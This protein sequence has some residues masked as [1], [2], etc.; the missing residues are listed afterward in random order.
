MKSNKLW[1]AIGAT[2]SITAALTLGSAS[3]AQDSGYKWPRMLVVATP[4]T[5]S[6]SFASTNGWAPV[7]QKE[8]G[9]TMRVVPEDSELMR[10]KRLNIDKNVQ[11]SSV[12]S[13]EVSYQIEGRDGYAAAEPVAQRI[14]WHHN[15]TPWGMVVAGDSKLKTIDDLKKG[16]VRVAKGMWSP[17]MMTTVTAS[18]PAYLNL[19]KEEAEKVIRY[20]PIS[21]YA[22]NCRSVVEGKT[23]AAWCAT[24]SA[25]SAEMEGA[26]GS[27]RWLPMDLNNTE[28][29]DRYLDHSPMAIPTKISLGVPTSIGVDGITSPFLYMAPEDTD[30]DFAYNLAKWIHESHDAYKS[31]HP[32]A[33]RMSLETFRNYL[34]HTPL[35][36]HEGTVKYLREIGAWTEADDAWNKEAIARTDN[37]IKARKTAMAEARKARVKIDFQNQAFLDILRKHTKD[38]EVFRTRL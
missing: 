29:W 9:M 21:S 32:L 3:F 26:P 18:V 24:I 31:T 33:A 22:E 28:A 37:W 23:D 19:S 11:L 35:P 1:R 13:T 14:I 38:L 25:V 8:T 2:A 4:G 15:D 16:G 10:F 20:I 36:V 7:I 27:I 6:G 34:N 5:S 17:P 30:A 12:S